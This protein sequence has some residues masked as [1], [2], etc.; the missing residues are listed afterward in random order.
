LVVAI[1]TITT[2]MVVG[3]FNHVLAKARDARRVSEVRTLQTALA[4]YYIDHGAYPKSTECSGDENWQTG[5]LAIA[6]N[7][8]LARLPTDPT[9]TASWT[10]SNR[11][12]ENDKSGYCYM[13]RLVNLNDATS[14]GHPNWE[15]TYFIAFR[16][17]NPDLTLATRDGVT[18]CANQTFDFGGNDGFVITLG[19]SCRQ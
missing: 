3:S 6:L 5:P 16:L 4:A 18:T 11:S 9:N 1:I 8:H 13:S 17:E 14:G 15:G 7:D 19:E 2:T 12:W 10:T